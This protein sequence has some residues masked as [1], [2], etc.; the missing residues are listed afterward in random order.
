MRKQPNPPPPGK[1]PA[2]PPAPPRSNA[3]RQKAWRDGK[4]AAGYVFVPV[5]VRP[6]HKPAIRQ[7]E[8]ELN[9]L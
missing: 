7:L 8:K 2:P 9:E 6:R 3:Q 4:L 5:Y 1:K